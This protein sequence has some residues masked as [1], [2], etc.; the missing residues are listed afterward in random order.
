M[1]MPHSSFGVIPIHIPKKLAPNIGNSNGH[2]TAGEK[3][4]SLN[5]NK[6]R[7]SHQQET[8]EASGS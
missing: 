2:A 3:Q 4:K 8:Q 7:P 1:A 6:L 5:I